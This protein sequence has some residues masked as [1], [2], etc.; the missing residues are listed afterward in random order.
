M[1]NNEDRM[2]SIVGSAMRLVT[3]ELTRSL[4][5]RLGGSRTAVQAGVST[6]VAV[7][8]SG[9]AHHAGDPGFMMR[10]FNLVRESNVNGGLSS[11]P[12]LAAGAHPSLILE[13]GSKLVAMLFGLRKT[14]IEYVVAHHSGLGAFA[15]S[16]L[17]SFATPLTVGVLGQ[18]IHD[19]GLNVFSFSNLATSESEK[20]QSMLPA[21]M[22]DLLS[23][24]PIPSEIST[25]AMPAS[26]PQMMK[27]VFPILGLFVL[28]LIAWPLSGG[29]RSQQPAPPAPVARATPAPTSGPLGEFIKRKLP[30]STELNIPR[31]GIENKLINFIEDSSKPADKTTWFDFDRLT[32]DTGASTLQPS[33]V[34][35]LQNIAAILKAYPKIRAKIG[36]YTDNTGNKNT[37]LKLSENRA[38]N[39]MHELASRGVDASRLEAKGYGEHPVGDNATED[40]RQKNRRISLLVTE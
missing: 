14:A 4:A 24:G 38:V 25:A 6:S 18:Q 31:L 8:I 15:G 2:N 1:L 3:P 21:R 20:I 33:S 22:A 11:L 34:E 23:G 32:F 39:V 30:D 26:R 27:E 19:Q 28:A 9:I 17:M 13:Q 36:G 29:C 10:L 40:G 5:S 7:L 12:D 16:E 37:N 35:Q